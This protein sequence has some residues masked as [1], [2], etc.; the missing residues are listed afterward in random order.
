MDDLVADLIQEFFGIA[1]VGGNHILW[2]ALLETGVLAPKCQVSF[3]YRE[4]EV[5]NGCYWLR[6]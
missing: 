2:Y 4:A 5:G 3:F 6:A 1:K